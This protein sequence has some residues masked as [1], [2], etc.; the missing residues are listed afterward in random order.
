MG[1]TISYDQQFV[2]LGIGAG[3]VA[4]LRV[5]ANYINAAFTDVERSAGKCVKAHGDDAVDAGSGVGICVIS[6]RSDSGRIGLVQAGDRIKVVSAAGAEWCGTAAIDDVISFNTNGVGADARLYLGAAPADYSDPVFID[7]L[8]LFFE[9]L[10]LGGHVHNDEINFDETS[11]GGVALDDINRPGGTNAETDLAALIAAYDSVAN[12][13]NLLG[14]GV[15]RN[16]VISNAALNIDA[17]EDECLENIID[18]RF[19]EDDDNDGVVN[20][21]EVYN[22]AVCARSAAFVRRG[23]WSQSVVAGVGNDGIRAYA[24]DRLYTP[25]TDFQSRT[26][27][28]GAWVYATV[29]N[30]VIL[31]IF[32]GVGTTTRA[33]GGTAGSWVWLQVERTCDPAAN[34]LDVRIYGS[35]GTTFY[36]DGAIAKF[37]RLNFGYIDS[38]GSMM[39]LFM[40]HSDYENWMPNSDFKDWTNGLAVVP[41]FWT[42]AA[43]APVIAR[44]AVVIRG[45]FSMSVAGVLGDSVICQILNPN[46]FLNQNV[47]FEMWANCTV[48]GPATVT[49]QV[50]AGGI[51]FPYTI[52]VNAGWQRFRFRARGGGAG[53]S[54]VSI[55]NM[56]AST[57]L[58]GGL[59]WHRGNVPQEW[60]PST[61]LIPEKWTFG[62]GGALGAFPIFLD[63]HTL[64]GQDV[65]PVGSNLLVHK[66]Y[67]DSAAAPGGIVI[68]NYAVTLNGAPTAVTANVVGA[69]T[70]GAFHLPAGAAFI[71]TDHIQVLYTPGVGSVAS[72]A[73]VVVEGLRFGN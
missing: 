64:V 47:M 41:D 33:A 30:T 40:G 46:D 11:F 50:T 25:A 4:A 1:Y 2:N 43:G 42:V 57:I 17:F 31:E 15:H 32:D 10:G 3:E 13:H 14:G 22:G 60:T 73:C 52:T 61:G 62:T 12:G 58:Y 24:D 44:S 45:S 26:V 63:H 68:D 5:D 28:F 39:D 23:V 21:W 66:I 55:T 59:I 56:G 29:N 67:V 51:A 18:G 69:A 70:A 9:P 20:G 53:L 35:V 54:N 37:G 72:D 36:V 7:G 6:I 49:V 27:S 8:R 48:G 38:P 65:I 19:E 71:P 16:E 34:I